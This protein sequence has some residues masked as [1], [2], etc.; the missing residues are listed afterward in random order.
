MSRTVRFSVYVGL[1]AALWAGMSLG[2]WANE[3]AF[4]PD[5]HELSDSKLPLEQL[6]AKLLAARLDEETAERLGYILY[7]LNQL[8]EP[9]EL[10]TILQLLAVRTERSHSVTAYAMAEPLTVVEETSTLRL[11]AAS[12]IRSIAVAPAIQ[13]RPYLLTERVVATDAS[14]RRALA[15]RAVVGGHLPV[16]QP[17]AAQPDVPALIQ[18][19]NAALQNPALEWRLPDGTRLRPRIIIELVPMDEPRVDRGSA[20]ALIPESAVTERVII[21]DVLIDE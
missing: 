13:L 10:L 16:V 5:V 15:A 4:S 7:E 9:E 12:E 3:S 14:P 2:A 17:A 8:L 21:Q 20:R 6:A 19:L 11:P 18:Q 1:L